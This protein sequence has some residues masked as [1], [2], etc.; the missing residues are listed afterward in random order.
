MAKS[1]EAWKK[2]V[3]NK[4]IDF[5][6][7]SYDC[8]DVSKSWIMY[9]TDKPWQQVA[10]WG[11][12]KD[13]YANWY[14]TYLEKVPRGNAPK[15]GDIIVMN[16]QV[17]G[18]YGHTGVI[19]GI[20][21]QNVTLYQ[22]NTF[23]QQ[24]VYTGVYNAYVSYVTGFLRPK[25][26]FSISDAVALQPY[27]RVT[28]DVINYREG[29]NRGAKVIQQFA[30]NDVLD[31]KG[32]VNGE[33]VDGN[34]VWFVGRH[35]GGY[36]WSGGFHDKGTH[37]L[38]DLNPKPDP[39]KDF[40]RVVGNSV[41]NYRTEPHIMPDNV[42]RTF[43]P[44]EVLDF[45]AWTKGTLVDGSDVWFR[46]RYTGGWAHSGGFTNSATT[47]LT[48]VGTVVV[49][50]P[51]EPTYPA[52]TTDPDVTLVVNKKNP[53]PPTYAPS[54]LV[55]AGNGQKLRKEANDSMKLM[56]SQQTL[57]MASGYR[58]YAT[59]EQVYQENVDQYGQEQADR[60][61]ARPGHSEHQTGLTMD[62]GPIEE[63]FDT[64][65]AFKWLSDNAYKYGWILR[66]PAS[67][68]DVTGYMYEPWHWRYVGV[69]VATDM[70][71]KG[72]ATLEAYYG[73]EG[74]DYRPDPVE[75]TDPVDPTDPTDPVDPLP[76]L[77]PEDPTQ[78]PLWKVFEAIVQFLQS[79]INKLKGK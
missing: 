66:Y 41:I 57:V 26:P 48:E 35:T 18:G 64:T 5:D 55:D 37:D 54:D 61:S 34:N 69:T 3:Y 29:P 28:N 62:F 75:P 13:I 22:Q 27:Q 49:P 36:A 17:G 79:I 40:Q 10:G 51:P 19:V 31:F 14:S 58:S 42:I 46:G 45:D 7:A 6:N 60:Q 68:E 1:L 47:G 71:T 30:A 63:R 43:N 78:N 50:V 25:V 15:L 67:A 33:S 44:G 12:A 73:I 9:L 77:D 59:Q 11:N 56:K 23:T 32:W 4:R 8:V 2:S 74:G 76:P 65:A 52:P 21:G 39:L 53:L 70:R 24:P 16:G 38:A 72:V 20:D